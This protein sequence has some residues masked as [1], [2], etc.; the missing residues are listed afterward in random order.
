MATLNV[1]KYIEKLSGVIYKAYHGRSRYQISL[2]VKVDASRNTHLMLIKDWSQKRKIPERGY[3][4]LHSGYVVPI[5]NFYDIDSSDIIEP[6]SVLSKK[7]LT[8]LV[9]RYRHYLSARRRGCRKSN[10]PTVGARSIV[11]GGKCS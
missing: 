11:S 6:V 10:G 3:C 7:E 1:S 4:V 5:R 2:F 8:I 9:V